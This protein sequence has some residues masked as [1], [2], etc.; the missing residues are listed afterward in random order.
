MW[1]MLV[2]CWSN[3]FLEI[4]VNKTYVNVQSEVR[5]TPEPS[6]SKQSLRQPQASTKENDS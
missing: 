2:T 1:E 4:V 6:K 5:T 3:I